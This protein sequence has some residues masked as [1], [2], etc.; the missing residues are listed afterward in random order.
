MKVSFV[1]GTDGKVTDVK[2]LENVCGEPAKVKGKPVEW[3]L[4]MT[5]VFELR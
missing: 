4:N 3:A 1:I 5:I 2:I